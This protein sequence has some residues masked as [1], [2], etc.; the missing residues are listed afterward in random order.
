MPFQWKVGAAQHVLRTERVNLLI[1]L[2]FNSG[3]STINAAWVRIKNYLYQTVKRIQR[4]LYLNILH[5]LYQLLC[6]FGS[7]DEA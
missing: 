2:E 3:C 6:S 5:L 7:L 4:N 1:R